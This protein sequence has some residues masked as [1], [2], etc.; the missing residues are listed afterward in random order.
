MIFYQKHRI[1][2]LLDFNVLEF[3]SGIGVINI[4]LLSNFRQAG[5]KPS[6]TFEPSPSVLNA[7]SSVN[8]PNSEVSSVSMVPVCVAEK[9]TIDPV[10]VDRLT[11]TVFS[12]TDT[13]SAA[14]SGTAM[15][16]IYRLLFLPQPPP[17]QPHNFY[18]YSIVQIVQF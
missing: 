16:K 11:L 2:N 4:I 7:K 8:N 14:N 17:P 18:L 6:M 15:G 5:K 1:K 10:Q 13:Q 12:E 9:Y 3:L